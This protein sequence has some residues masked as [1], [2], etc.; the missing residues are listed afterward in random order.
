MLTFIY[1]DDY[2]SKNMGE[3][4]NLNEN[5]KL[6][7]GVTEEKLKNVEENLCRIN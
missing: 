4:L 5:G 7:L 2:I 6:F 1:T 3:S